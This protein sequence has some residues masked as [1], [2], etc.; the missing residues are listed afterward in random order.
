M[1][2][3]SYKFDNT[4]YDLIPTFNSGF[5]YT[6]TDA[7][8]GNITT[9]TIESDVLPTKIQFGGLTGSSSLLEVL[10]I[11]TSSVTTMGSMFNGCNALT[12]LD[13][14]N[15]DTKNVTNMN[16]MFRNCSSLTSLDVSRWN[17]SSVMNMG[18]MFYGCN[19]LT[20]LDV[21]NF[22][23]KNVTDMGSMFNGCNKLTS[24]DVSNFDTKNVTTMIDMFNNCNQLTSLDISGFDTSNVTN[25]QNMFQ[26][27]NALTSLDV[28]NFDTKN[29]TNMS[30]MLS[31]CNELTDIGLLYSS[32]ETV[33]KLQPNLPFTQTNPGTLW[34]N[35]IPAS[36]VDTANI[37]YRTFESKTTD[38]Y[39]DKPLSEGD[40]LYWD[41]DKL[42]YLIEHE[43]GS[44]EQTDIIRQIALPTFKNSVGINCIGGIQSGNI[45][46]TV[47]FMEVEDGY[48]YDDSH[49]VEY[50]QNSF[51]LRYPDAKEVGEDYGYLG[52]KKGVINYWYTQGL[53]YTVVMTHPK[54]EYV[55]SVDSSK[56]ITRVLTYTNDG[57][58]QGVYGI[59]GFEF[60]MSSNGTPR[61]AFGSEELWNSITIDG[62]VYYP[63]EQINASI[64]NQ[65]VGE[66][67]IRESGSLKRVIEWVDNAPKEEFK[68]NF[69]KYFNK[70]Y[71]FRYYL[72]VVLIG[73]IDNLG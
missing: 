12:S 7:V 50:L 24:L 69:D 56:P 72:L 64:S 62:I 40:K 22:N 52:S 16:N 73:A 58:W 59:N 32:V 18:A 8:D 2:I 44:I 14:S 43:D 70:H 26:N 28:S 13:V 71:T 46:V 6:H 48:V 41:I 29:V 19:T 55:V 34:L 5:T 10:E 37:K 67:Y 33:K 35:Q 11:D 38:V 66:P 1:L 20:S 60:T 17:T 4:T 61:V 68:A 27:C 31:G 23:T 30:Y 36:C 39:L 63:G 15:F 9:R 49:Y 51:E 57:T 3:C 21:S 42:K 47:P 53:Y 54:T 25:M 45:K 65:A